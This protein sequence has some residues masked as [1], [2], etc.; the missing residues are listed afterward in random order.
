[1]PT[2]QTNVR[3]FRRVFAFAVSALALLL[4]SPSSAQ[5]AGTA[6]TWPETPLKPVVPYRPDT[7]APSVAEPLSNAL[8]RPVAT[9][10]VAD[11]S[12]EAD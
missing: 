3:A 5:T 4:S 1:M 10:T 8:S 6:S 2:P 9:R 12:A 11:S 7:L